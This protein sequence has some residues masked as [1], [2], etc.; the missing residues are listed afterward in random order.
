MHYVKA[1][2]ALGLTIIAASAQGAE[3]VTYKYDAKGRLVKVVRS[4]SINNGVNVDYT[5]DKADNRK[6]LLVS[7]SSN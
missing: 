3:T 2:C 6:R 1:I 4:G 7:G 5:H